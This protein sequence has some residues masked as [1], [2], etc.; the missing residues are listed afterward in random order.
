[1]AG[2]ALNL[3]CKL[4]GSPQPEVEWF[5]DG[6][7]LEESD[8]VMCTLNDGVANLVIKKAE[9]DDEGWYRCRISNDKGA[10]AV[11]A[12]VI[13][14]EVPKFVEP[15]EDLEIDE[16]IVINTFRYIILGDL[17]CRIFIRIEKCLNAQICT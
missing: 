17:L 4:T 10:A 3:T 2:S 16:G 11:E 7:P 12:E 15:L 14:V 1:M 6:G 9:S 5:K 13:V 8:R